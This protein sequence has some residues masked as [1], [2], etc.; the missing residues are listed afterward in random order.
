MAKTIEMILGAPPMSIFDMIANDMRASF[1][2]TPDLTPYEA[3][4]PSQSIY[5]LNPAVNVLAGQKRLDAI[6]S[7]KMDWQR[8]PDNV[9]AERAQPDSVAHDVRDTEYPIW[10]KG[11][12][13]FR[14]GS[15]Q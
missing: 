8:E 7:S 10:K 11:S 13:V 9:P 15:T 3:V 14:S 12:A 6:A 4:V 1:Q 2:S 5:E